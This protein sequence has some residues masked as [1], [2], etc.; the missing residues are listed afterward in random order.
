MNRSK[1]LAVDDEAGILR[2]IKDSLAE[3]FEVVTRNNAAD[4]IAAVIDERPDLILFDNIMPGMS[5]LEAI[6]TLRLAQSANKIPIIMLTALKES[7]DRIEAFKAGVD[8][9]ISKPFRPEE[10]LARVESRIQRFEALMNPD[11]QVL[12]LGNLSLN[13]ESHD[14]R[15]DN[16]QIHL[17]NIEQTI[18]QKL[19]V[20]LNSVVSRTELKKIVWPET[21]GDDRLLDIHMATLRK[22]LKS[23][24]HKIE[25]IYGKGYIV[26][27]HKK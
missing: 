7:G 14:V 19:L 23:F 21:F 24:S 27:G 13:K 20:E 4:A 1:V 11:I 22:K 26:R 12:K 16:I 15:I 18:L 9:F 8:D 25:T 3:K 5:G 10:L 17:T 6:R 2:I